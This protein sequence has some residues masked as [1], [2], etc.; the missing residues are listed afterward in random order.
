MAVFNSS[1][2]RSN[3][4]PTRKESH[5]RWFDYLEERKAEKLRQID[6]LETGEV[7]LSATISGVASDITAEELS[8]LKSEVAQIRQV[9]L[10]EGMTPDA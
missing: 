2:D 10:D 3:R 7:E 9:I 5:M 4:A 6:R 8:K 1:P